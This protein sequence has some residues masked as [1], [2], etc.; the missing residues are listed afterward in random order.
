LQRLFLLNSELM[1]DSA[2]ALDKA[3][4]GATPEDRIRKGYRAVLGR[5]PSKAE[6]DMGVGYVKAGGDAWAQY[7][8]VL[9]ATDEFLMVR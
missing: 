4:E 7:W 2:G 8:Q 6:L 5:A 3:I 9:L 1:A